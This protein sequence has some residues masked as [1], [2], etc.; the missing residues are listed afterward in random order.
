MCESIVFDENCKFLVHGGEFGKQS[1]NQLFHWITNGHGNLRFSLYGEYG[2]KLK[3]TTQFLEVVKELVMSGNASPV[4][5]KDIV[6]AEKIL[7]N[8]LKK[9]K[10]KSHHDDYILVLTIASKSKILCTN[11]NELQGRFKTIV[12]YI[13]GKRVVLYPVGQPRKKRQ[14]F[15]NRHKCKLK[16]TH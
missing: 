1:D 6:D 5:K 3:D 4:S 13:L 16:K 2:D 11:D 7:S 14:S 10:L 8:H 12:S 15:L 9:V